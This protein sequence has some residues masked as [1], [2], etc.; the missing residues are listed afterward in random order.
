MIRRRKIGAFE[1]DRPWLILCEGR[2]DKELLHK[3][4]TSDP[5]LHN[6][7]T[8]RFPS[9]ESDSTGGRGKFGNWLRDVCD[10]APSFGENVRGV[11]IVSD[12]DADR[13]GSLREITSGLSAAGLPTPSGEGVEARSA[14]FPATI[15]IYLVPHDTL[16]SLD[17]LCVQALGSKWNLLEVVEEY[18]DKTPAVAWSATKRG[19]AMLHALLA[20][21]C[22][23]KPEAT[24]ST[25]WQ[26]CA[27]YHIPLDTNVFDDLIAKLASLRKSRL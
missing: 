24:L 17:T 21:T 7:F 22:A 19:K 8:I 11:V 5:S 13:S 14:G 1:F 26:E 16:G 6:T 9:R 20:A 18:I 27:K 23:T 15:I 4:I 25:V 12:V 10:T 2:G 3:L